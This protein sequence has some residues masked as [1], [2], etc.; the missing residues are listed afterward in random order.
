MQPIRQRENSRKDSLGLWRAVA[1][2]DHFSRSLHLEGS[3][4]SRRLGQTGPSSQHQ[5]L[6]AH[7]DPLPPIPPG[8]RPAPVISMHKKQLAKWKR[9]KLQLDRAE[10]RLMASL[11]PVLDTNDSPL[12]RAESGA[13]SSL[14]PGLEGA[15]FFVEKDRT[16]DAQ[17]QAPLTLAQKMGIVDRPAALLTNADWNHIKMTFMTRNESSCSI[18]QDEFRTEDQILLS[19][20]HVFHRHCIESYERFVGQKMCPMCRQANY[21]KRLI[22]EGK[23]A[24]LNRAATM[25]QK[26][27]RMWKLHR[28]YLQYRECHPPTDP[29]LL[30]K[31]HL[32]KLER[33]SRKLEQA[34]R[35]ETKGLGAFFRQLDAQVSHSRRIIDRSTQEFQRIQSLP[36][37][38]VEDWEQ[39]YQVALDR[40]MWDSNCTICLGPIRPR[41]HS[42]RP[43]RLALT[44]CSHVF[45]EPCLES[46]ERF[47]DAGS[48]VCP[49]CRSP[50]QRQE[51]QAFEEPPHP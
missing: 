27:W 41:A 42:K 6:P 26:T 11:H 14:G 32:D 50:Y 5:S 36:T 28:A 43:K 2:Q 3:G 19:C 10:R 31:Y 39:T 22:F 1:L 8:S 16:L 49:V 38:S 4:P 37:L 18:C 48:R 21:Q 47:A 40:D 44:S 29:K 13:G 7:L 15:P 9:E 33:H 51:L 17:K 20:S 12:H 25:I 30:R 35:S 45:H 46:F 23:R 24:Y 34:V